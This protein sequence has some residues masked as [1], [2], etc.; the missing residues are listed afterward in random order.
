MPKYII[1][2]KMKEQ[3]S[4]DDIIQDRVLCDK[5][6]RGLNIINKEIE[7]REKLKRELIEL[8]IAKDTAG[9]Y[10]IE[11]KP[12]RFTDYLH[13]VKEHPDIKF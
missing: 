1:K 13:Y 2:A 10:T 4:K 11:I 3:I 9:V 8:G 12:E 7:N 5:I 6:Q